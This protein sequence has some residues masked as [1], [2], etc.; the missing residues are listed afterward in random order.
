MQK[1]DS[2][3]FSRALQCAILE[4]SNLEMDWL[5][6]ATQLSDPQEQRYCY[7]QA[8]RINPASELAR[9]ALKQLEDTPAPALLNTP[10]CDPCHSV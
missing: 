9:T 10:H 8:L 2:L 1:Q 6:L 5:W 7:Q 3:R 4:C